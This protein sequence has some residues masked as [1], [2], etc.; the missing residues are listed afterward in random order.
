VV[1]IFR[2]VRRSMGMITR[3]YETFRNIASE[4]SFWELTPIGI[5]LALYLGIASLLKTSSF[6]PYFLTRQ[7]FLLAAAVCVTYGFIVILLYIIGKLVG[8]T[9]TIKRVAIL[10][11][12]T[13]FPTLC[14]FLATSILYII[15]PPPRS[16]QAQG[17]IFSVLYLLFSVIL[18]GWKIITAYLTLRFGMR[19]D[20]LRIF[21]ACCMLFPILSLF[22][23]MSYHAGVFRIPFF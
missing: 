23:W 12:Y 7:F 16:T 2:G 5:L 1:S 17:L 18:L 10:W 3:P 21:L 15:I 13:L 14:W 6:R 9:G 4:C 19:L 22:S 8:G 20:L 11:G